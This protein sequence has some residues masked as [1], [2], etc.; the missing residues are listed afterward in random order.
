MLEKGE[1]RKSNQM[2]KER[3]SWSEMVYTHCMK[4][5]TYGFKMGH[6]TFGKVTNLMCVKTE[7]LDIL[8]IEYFLLCRY[9]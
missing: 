1:E 7:I 9:N 4:G 8:N 6:K 2:Q 5:T 3:G